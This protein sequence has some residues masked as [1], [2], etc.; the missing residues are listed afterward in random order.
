[1]WVGFGSAVVGLVGGVL[2]LVGEVKV[3]SHEVVWASVGVCF[4][5]Q[6][7]WLGSLM[8]LA[9]LGELVWRAFVGGSVSM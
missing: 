9:M 4:G 6:V 8:V 7:G 3:F 5:N 1:M 2:W